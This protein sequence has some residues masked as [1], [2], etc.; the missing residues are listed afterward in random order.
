MRNG[1]QAHRRTLVWGLADA[2]I[3]ALGTGDPMRWV[4][5]PAA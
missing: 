5:E 4:A 2:G 1:D 3:T